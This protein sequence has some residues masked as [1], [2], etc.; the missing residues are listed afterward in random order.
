M[1]ENIDSYDK[2]VKEIYIKK[3]RDD[4][5]L[6][7]RGLII[8]SAN[9]PELFENCIADFQLECFRELASALHAVRDGVMPID[10]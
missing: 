2:E 8:P 10:R 4:F 9:G 3:S 1:T 6:F 7:A 5:L